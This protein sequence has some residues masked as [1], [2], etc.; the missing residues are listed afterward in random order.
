MIDDE[1]SVAPSVAPVQSAESD[2][3]INTS[4]RDPL[5][6]SLR[7]SEKIKMMQL[8]DRWEEP[9]RNDRYKVRYST[10]HR[11]YWLG[12]Y[13]VP[14][15]AFVHICFLERDGIHISSTELP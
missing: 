15:P 14:D 3:F 8:L 7:F 12:K 4:N 9:E 13:V 10:M 11:Y 6:G 1:G 2:T 5:T